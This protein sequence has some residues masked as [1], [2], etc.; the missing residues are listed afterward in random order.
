[1]RY[2]SRANPIQEVTL[3]NVLSLLVLHCM[4]SR[5]SPLHVLLL[6]LLLVWWL[7]LMLPVLPVI[8]RRSVSMNEHEHE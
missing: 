7:P 6:V 4:L 3:L 2:P 5:Y 1:M 8:G